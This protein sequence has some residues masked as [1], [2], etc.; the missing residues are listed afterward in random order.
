LLSMASVLSVKANAKKNHIDVVFDNRKWDED[1]IKAKVIEINEAV[2]VN[3]VAAAGEDQL[4][5]T[6]SDFE[7]CFLRVQGMTCA[8]C[9][10]A[11]EKYAKKIDGNQLFR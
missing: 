10:A 3:D 11:I 9:V 1:V 2:E 4:E 8:S 7:K 6:N 5:T